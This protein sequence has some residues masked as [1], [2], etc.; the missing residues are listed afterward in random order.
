MSYFKPLFHLQAPEE[1][2]SLDFRA[3]RARLPGW[4]SDG[5]ARCGNR[6][7]PLA[8]RA[9]VVADTGE[10]ALVRARA[11]RTADEREPVAACQS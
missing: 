8:R 6:T 2:G 7:T 9:H 1:A 11:V 5:L 4:R 10:G 3:F